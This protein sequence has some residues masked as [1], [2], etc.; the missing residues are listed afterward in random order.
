MPRAQGRRDEYIWYGCAQNLSVL[1][2][3]LG[4]RHI[5]DAYN[6]QLLKVFLKV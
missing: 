1:S 6:F 4:S 5:L 3:E 2:S